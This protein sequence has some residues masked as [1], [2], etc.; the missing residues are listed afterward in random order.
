MFICLN[1]RCAIFEIKLS[2][3]YHEN[4]FRDLPIAPIKI[5]FPLFKNN[6]ILVLSFLKLFLE[7]CSEEYLSEFLIITSHIWPRY[8]YFFLLWCSSFFSLYSFGVIVKAHYY[9]FSK[10]YSSRQESNN[11]DKDL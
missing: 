11:N 3:N 1:K 5:L 10:Y 9:V 4:Q 2:L 7:K 8:Y 6:V